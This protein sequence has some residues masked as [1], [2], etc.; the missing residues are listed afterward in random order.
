M[1]AV[2]SDSRE[3]ALDLHSLLVDLDAAR[4]RGANP[5]ARLEEIHERAADLL[6]HTWPDDSLT[7]LQDRLDEIATLI[8]S[9]APESVWGRGEWAA[10]RSQALPAYEALAASLRDFEI[11][12]PSLRPTNTARNVF[13]VLNAVMVISCV[14]FFEPATCIAISVTGMVGALTMEISR[15]VDPRINAFLMSVF[16]RVAHPHEAHRVNSATWYTLAILILALFSDYRAGVVGLAVLGLG[17]PMA[18]LIGRRFGQVKL[19]AGRTLEGSLAFVA[20][21]TV[22]AAIVLTLFYPDVP[23]YVALVGG[24]FGAV[25]ELFTKR[26]DDNLAVPLVAALGAWLVM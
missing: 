9:H 1:H 23:L 6:A 17:D 3:L 5:A 14:Q 13:H 24:V 4:F 11:H 10:F 12:V 16:N 25:A 21:G 15:R 7:A 8:E 26:I 18:A 22:G 2:T 19:L 20:F